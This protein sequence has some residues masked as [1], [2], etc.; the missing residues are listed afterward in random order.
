MA[1]LNYIK[2]TDKTAFSFEIVPPL[3]GMGIN[4]LYDNIQKLIEFNPK[5]INITSRR[6]EYI[7]KELSNGNFKRYSI[8]T[9]PGTVAVAAAIKNKFA[10]PVVPHVLCGGFT[11]EETEYLLIDLQFLGITDLLV[12]R[13]DK[14]RDESRFTPTGNGYNHAIELQGQINDFN[15]GIFVDEEKM[16]A[17]I[18]PFTYG[19]ACYPE[20]HEEAPNMET[21]IYWL[22]KK[23]EAGAQYAVTQMFYDNT[24]Y[25]DFVKRAQKEGI[26]VPIIPGIKPLGKL[27][28]INILPKTFKIDLPHDLMKEADKCTTDAEVQSVGIEWGI[29]Q[30]KEL[31]A[32]GVPSIHFY[33][34]GA[35]ESIRQIAKQ[36]Y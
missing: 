34:I 25:F 33:S 27:S 23:V 16:K 36:I 14:G 26:T 11:R 35:T 31:I 8:R 6:S 19:V 10:V 18:N 13:G 7:Y 28:Q 2:N 30:C 4:K 12:L 20:K 24:K 5:Y 22:K 29:Q 9:R 21:D 32:H 15:N 1:I 17:A 3:K